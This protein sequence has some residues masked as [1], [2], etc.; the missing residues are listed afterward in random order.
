M[1]RACLGSL[2]FL[3]LLS[4]CDRSP[5]RGGS[6]IADDVYWRLNMLGDG[7]RT[8]TDSDSV[9]VRV[10]ITG[11]GSPPV[12]LYSAERWYGMGGAKGTS[13]YFARLRQGDNATVML[14]SASAPWKDIG[15]TLPI[16]GTDTGWVTMDLTML[17]LRSLGEYREMQRTILMARTRSDEERI[18]TDFFSGSK[19]QW[20]QALGVYYVLDSS[21]QRGGPRVQS[22]ELVTLSYTASFLDNGSVFDQQKEG[23]L[24]RLG[25]PDQVIKGLEAAAHLLPR[26][27]GSGRFIIP[28]ELAFG[29]QG[30]SSGIVPPWTPVL[31]EVRV[32]P[33][34][35]GQTRTR[36]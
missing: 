16:A 7:E 12:T 28:S 10:R 36:R 35:A 2:L 11:P 33:S 19:V 21:I 20:K 29:P 27:G 23:L 14:P 30:S 26:K 3:A 1:I 4:G 15:A 9:Q 24:F 25:D 22:G 5:L 6:K 13:K 34:T 32:L 31:Y 18:L 17:D 8:P